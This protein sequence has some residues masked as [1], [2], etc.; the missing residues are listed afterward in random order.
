[1]TL[2]FGCGVQLVDVIVFPTRSANAFLEANKTV[3]IKI[4]RLYGF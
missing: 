4:K 3:V 1:M 2:I